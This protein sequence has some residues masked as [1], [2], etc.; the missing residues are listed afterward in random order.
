M[1]APYNLCATQTDL[2]KEDSLASGTWKQKDKHFE[3]STKS[4]PKR[5]NGCW[6]A[7]RSTAPARGREARE[8]EKKLRT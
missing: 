3:T 8:E 6:A 4:G 5:E 7:E 1:L 2:P